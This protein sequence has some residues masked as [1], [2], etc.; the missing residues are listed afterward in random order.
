MFSITI[1]NVKQLISALIP[2]FK[3]LVASQDATKMRNRRSRG[4]PGDSAFAAVVAVN[5]AGHR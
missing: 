3:T 1:A 2:D 4:P 5:D